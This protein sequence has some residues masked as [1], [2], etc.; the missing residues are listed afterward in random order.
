MNQLNR[1]DV[2]QYVEDNIGDF[3]QKRIKALSKLKLEKVLKRKNPYMFKAKIYN[4]S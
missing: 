1:G 3:H 2:V 4:D